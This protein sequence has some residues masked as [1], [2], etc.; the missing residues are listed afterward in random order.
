MKKM[1]EVLKQS[2]FDKAK[3]IILFI[4]EKGK[5][6]PKEAEKICGKSTATVRRYLKLLAQ[7][8]YMVTVTLTVIN[9]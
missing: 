4:E 5:K 7:T 1:S 6:T 2:D 9:I 3:N 8:G